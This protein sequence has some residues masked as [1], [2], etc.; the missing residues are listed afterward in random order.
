MA[1]PG[2]RLGA[3][4][5]GMRPIVEIMYPDFVLMAADQL[6]NQAAKVR[7]MF[8][9]TY[10][11]PMV[12]RSRVAAGT[13]YGSQHSMDAAGLFACYPGW[14]IVSPSTPFDYIGLMNAA[15]Q[16]DDPVLIVEYQDLFQD[17]GLIPTDDRDYVV[18]LGK[19][20]TVRPG[21]DCTVLVWSEMVKHAVNTAEK[22]G[23][24]AEIIDLRTIDP[25]GL[26]WEAVEE[27]VKK[28]NRLL[29][30]EETTRGTSVGARIVEMAQTRLFDW[31]DHEIVHV[32]GTDS[33]PVVSKVLE[34]AALAGPAEVEAGFQMV[35]GRGDGQPQ[36]S[37]A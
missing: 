2:W 15:I 22:L 27:S 30:S 9:G 31:L 37:A 19:S 1:L 12:V 4:I 24:D 29:I 32:T 8:G 23:I 28:T 36:K 35:M 3:A 25:L 21:S 6:F 11:V 14:R 16:C 20:R 34:E 7:H 10:P 13:G 18:P 26:D 33:S 5:N 17:M